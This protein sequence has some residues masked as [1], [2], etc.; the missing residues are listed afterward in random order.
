MH[1]E[2]EKKSKRNAVACQYVCA[3]SMTGPVEKDVQVD[4]VDGWSLEMVDQDRLFG[5]RSSNVMP[6]VSTV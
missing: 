1:D 2:A 6:I 3:T 5:M 4:N